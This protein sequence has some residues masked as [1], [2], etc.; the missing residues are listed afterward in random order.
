[1]IAGCSKLQHFMDSFIH[2]SL[3]SKLYPGQGHGGSEVYL[4]NTGPKAGIHPEFDA[5]VLYTW[6]YTFLS[7]TISYT[8][9]KAN[10]G[11]PQ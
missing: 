5:T 4:R 7:K 3:F 9:A 6:M 8:F 2:S 11:K 10:K 1:M